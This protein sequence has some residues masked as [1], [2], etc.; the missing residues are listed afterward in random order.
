MTSMTSYAYKEVSTER[1]F[2]SVEIK[3]INSRFLDLNIA[4]PPFLGRLEQDINDR[5]SDKRK[6]R[7]DGAGA[8]GMRREI[9]DAL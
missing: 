9:A 6:E 2:I 3:S 7:F 1:M 8:E 4:L 5:I